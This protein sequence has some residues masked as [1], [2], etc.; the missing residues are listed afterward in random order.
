MCICKEE[1][2]MWAAIVNGTTRFIKKPQ[3]EMKCPFTGEDI[4]QEECEENKGNP[5]FQPKWRLRSPPIITTQKTKTLTSSSSSPSSSSLPTKEEV[6]TKT[7][8]YS[9]QLYIKRLQI[10]GQ[11]TKFQYPPIF[12]IVTHEDLPAGSFQELRKRGFRLAFSGESGY[13]REKSLLTANNIW[14]ICSKMETKRPHLEPERGDVCFPAPY[15]TPGDVSSIDLA[16][17]YLWPLL[18]SRAADVVACRTFGDWKRLFNETIHLAFP[19]YHAMIEYKK[20]K[21]VYLDSWEKSKCKIL[22]DNI[23]PERALYLI[24]VK[25]NFWP[26]GRESTIPKWD[27]SPFS[28]SFESKN[29]QE[30]KAELCEMKKQYP[31]N[32][33]FTMYETSHG[34]DGVT[35]IKGGR[36]ASGLCAVKKMKE[37]GDSAEIQWFVNAEFLRNMKRVH[38]YLESSPWPDISEVIRDDEDEQDDSD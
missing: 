13:I 21:T 16:N 10:W 30:R 19:S 22:E 34:A 28:L 3:N 14:L 9:N 25:S 23:N 29:Y 4:T 37:H 24:S 15:N 2:T 11:K 6:W 36:N 17:L 7:V 27:R 26:Y 35:T 1:K 12:R 38:I 8:E 32:A 20:C 31:K 18:H 33:V 5:R